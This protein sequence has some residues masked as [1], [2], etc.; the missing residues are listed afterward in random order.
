MV[1]AVLTPA[2]AAAADLP[3][4]PP[5]AA[6]PPDWIVTLG[7]V[8]QMNPA[9]PGAPTSE[10]NFTGVP[11]VSV[12]RAGT[13]PEF[14][15]PR[16]SMGFALIDLGKLK[17]GPAARLIWR[18]DASDYAALNGLGDV[19]YALQ[20]GAFAEYWPV[21]WLRL[22][23][24]VRQGFGGETGVTGDLFLDAVDRIGP[25]TL[26][27]GPRVTLQSADAISP[28]F[29]VTAAQSAASGVSGLPPLP[30][31][32]ASGGLYSY[33]G[34]AQARYFWTPQWSS[35]AYLEYERLAGDAADSPLVTQRGSPNQFTVGLGVTYS[36]AMHPFW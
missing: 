10:M 23:G 18:R 15:G 21:P 17:I 25:L 2:M 31:Y 33:G 12:R 36:F 29:S 3:A 4:A 16:D 26:S 1:L 19:D 14:F 13:P 5:A 24:E 28:Y 22:R 35:L 34:G 11:L 32:Q 30:V 27:A 9:W 8:G 7:L 20:V 6:A